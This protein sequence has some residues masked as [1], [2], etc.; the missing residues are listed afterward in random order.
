L[1]G[2]LEM[3]NPGMPR[4]SKK[5]KLPAHMKEAAARDIEQGLFKDEAEWIE[6]LSPKAKEQYG[7]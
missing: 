1:E 6:H 2:D 5:A 3:I 4:R 7:L